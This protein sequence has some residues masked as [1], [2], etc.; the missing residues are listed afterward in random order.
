MSSET[1]TGG[2]HRETEGH[3]HQPRDPWS[4]RSWKRREGPSLEPVKGARPWDTWASHVWSPRW[5]RVNPYVL[6][7]LPFAVTYYGRPKRF[8][9]PSVETGTAVHAGSHSSFALWF[10]GRPLLFQSSAVPS[11]RSSSQAKPSISFQSFMLHI[12][13]I[14]DPRASHHLQHTEVFVLVGFFFLPPVFLML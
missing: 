12:Q 1:D 11:C 2:S 5:D 3:G 13:R 10:Q 7:D 4:P 6:Y 9:Q 14:P 8:L